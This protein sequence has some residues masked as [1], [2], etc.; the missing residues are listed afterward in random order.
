MTIL[1]EGYDEPALIARAKSG[2]AE[3]FGE[4]YRR[5]RPE[6]AASVGRK[7]RKLTGRVDSEL[8]DDIVSETYIRAWRRVS[9]YQDQGKP[10]V[11]WLHTIA[12]NM[13]VD[14]FRVGWG[15]YERTTTAVAAA[16]GEGDWFER[17]APQEQ[18]PHVLVEELST[19]AW[20]AAVLT[21]VNPYQ[22]EALLR[23]HYLDQPVQEA[24]EA[25]GIEVGAYKTLV[26]RALKS[27]RKHAGEG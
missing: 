27:A 6:V 14:Y 21:S 2:C 7:L 26:C 5:T 1:L 10:L 12:G 25:M 4:L 8:L 16:V 9:T 19:V 15:R 18:E 23:R 22:R 11:A 13:T 20:L 17:P 24:A 3:S